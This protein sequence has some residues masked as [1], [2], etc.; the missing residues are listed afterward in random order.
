MVF[1]FSDNAQA[2]SILEQNGIKVLKA[3]GNS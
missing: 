2:G 1:R 3:G